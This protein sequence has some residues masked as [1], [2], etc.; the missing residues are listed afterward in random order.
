MSNEYYLNNPLIHRD[1]RL[2]RRHTA[3]VNQFPQNM[4]LSVAAA[5][6]SYFLLEKPLLALRHRLRVA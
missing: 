5:L 4:A 1:R 6:A 3:W 2:A